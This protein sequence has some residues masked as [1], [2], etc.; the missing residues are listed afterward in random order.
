MGFAR[1]G[2][3]HESEARHWSFGVDGDNGRMD[4]TTDLEH[5]SRE[6]E[7]LAVVDPAAAAEIASKLADDLA[8]A[9]DSLEEGSEA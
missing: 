4:A 2:S 1:S 5:L 8:H 6:L 7:E 3:G 9:L